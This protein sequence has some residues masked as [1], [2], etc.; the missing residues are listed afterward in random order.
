NI[1]PATPGPGLNWDTG[2][3]A[4]SGTLNII[5]GATQPGITSVVLS[6]TNLVFSGSNGS[7]NGSFSVLTTTN[8]LL[9]LGRWTTNFSSQF[10]GA[11]NFSVT[12][13]VNPAAPQQF[14]ILQ[15]P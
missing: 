13:G 1:V 3:L 4:S 15:T 5:A 7:L 14:Y 12:N 11:G 2:S 6:G 10:D 8:L 9:P